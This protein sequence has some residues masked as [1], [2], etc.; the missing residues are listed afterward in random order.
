ML[1][2]FWGSQTEQYKVRAIPH[3]T[4]QDKFLTDQRPKCKKMK[5]QGTLGD[6]WFLTK[7]NKFYHTIQ[8]PHSYVFTQ[9]R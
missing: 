1:S 6:W 8:Q 4:Q 9:M 5:S 7:L 3:T 2:E